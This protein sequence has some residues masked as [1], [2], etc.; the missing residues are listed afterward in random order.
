MCARYT[1]RTTPK[2]L[3]NSLGVEDLPLFQPRFNISPTQTVL[4]VRTR[5]DRPAREAVFLRW[6]LVPSWAKELRF[7]QKCI[8]ARADTVA[9]KPAFRTAFKQRRCL[10]AADGFYEWQP[11]GDKKQ[12][13]HFRLKEG[14][15]F[16]FA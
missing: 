16:A 10:V 12:P 14:R 7:G 5:D 13:W 8:N 2:I 9:E 6:G 1:L 15:P 3:A 4:A 11:V